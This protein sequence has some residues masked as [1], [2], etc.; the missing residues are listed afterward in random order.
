MN[1]AL[2]TS[3]RR[4]LILEQ[5]NFAGSVRISELSRQFQVSQMTIRRDVQWLD[6]QGLVRRVHGGAEPVPV[7]HPAVVRTAAVSVD[8]RP[9]DEPLFPANSRVRSAEKRAIA[10][11][12]A[13]YVQPGA[14]VG[15]SGA[16]TPFEVARAIRDVPD[17][18]VVTNSIPVAQELTFERPDRHL[19]LTGGMHTRSD[20][21]VGPIAIRSLTGLRIDR[22]FVGAQGVDRLAGLTSPSM[23][24]A[25][26]NSAL[27]ACAR[28]VC[29]VFD[30]SKWGVQA[31]Y[32]FA[33]W[34]AIHE[35]ISD[36]GLDQ[37]A[38]TALHDRGVELTIAAAGS[39][40]SEVAPSIRE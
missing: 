27:M 2:L 1:D 14:I 32:A 31:L 7:A 9:P 38:R 23:A 19:V 5:L 28:H 34:S 11:V 25:D 8:R 33:D 29:L 40:A 13:Q 35:A 3:R 37:E 21:V 22:L 24:E 39:E 15:F 4:R 18:Q 36:E 17:V 10:A 26:T 30:S 20:C 6:A 12:A 16:T